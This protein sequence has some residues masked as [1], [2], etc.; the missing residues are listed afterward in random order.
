MGWIDPEGDYHYDPDF[1]D[2]SEWAGM[3]AIPN[4]PGAIEE[5][6][7]RI[8]APPGEDLEWLVYSSGS[9]GEKEIRNMLL[10]R[11]WVKVSNAYTV[12]VWEPTRTIL[13]SW[14]DLGMEADCDPEREFL[15]VGRGNKPLVR[16]DW[17]AIERY[18]KG[19]PG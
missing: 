19:L 17:H 8:E 15:V 13:N 14:L 10:E 11:G 18:V 12:E 5:L 16:G 1:P 9:R 7:Q 3:V 2:H 6:A 4:I